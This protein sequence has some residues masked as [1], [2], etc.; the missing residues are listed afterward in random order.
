[1]GFQIRISALFKPDNNVVKWMESEP[2]IW[3]QMQVHPR[4]YWAVS[5][6]LPSLIYHSSYIK[7]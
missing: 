1:M 2:W 4:P 3:M 7:E 6:T 5:G